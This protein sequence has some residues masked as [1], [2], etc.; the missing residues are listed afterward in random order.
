M[1]D[2]EHEKMR[3]A[4]RE[5]RALFRSSRDRLDAGEITAAAHRYTERHAIRAIKIMENL[6]TGA[7][8]S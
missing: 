8:E 1:T 4:L 3:A 6:L 5:I 2:H 7:P